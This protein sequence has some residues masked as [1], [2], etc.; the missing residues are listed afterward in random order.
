MLYTLGRKDTHLAMSEKEDE[1]LRGRE[2][3][4][5]ICQPFHQAKPFLD[6]VKGDEH[7][8]RKDRIL[9][10]IILRIHRGWD[11]SSDI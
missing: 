9:T 7:D 10:G 3:P 11:V 6:A 5:L 4:P 8:T 2:K 1:Q